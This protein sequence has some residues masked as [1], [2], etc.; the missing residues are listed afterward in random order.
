MPENKVLTAVH[1]SCSLKMALQGV[2]TFV[3]FTGPVPLQI[4]CSEDAEK[5][6]MIYHTFGSLDL[7]FWTGVTGVKI[8]MV[9]NG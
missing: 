2:Q 7:K 8:K 5:S 3:K 4:N 6:V 1:I 9:I